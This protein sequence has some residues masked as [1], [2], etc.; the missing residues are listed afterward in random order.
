MEIVK[1]LNVPA[2]FFFQKMMDSVRYDIEQATGKQ[3]LVEQME[4]FTYVKEFSNKS[5]AKIQ[6]G[7]IEQDRSYGYQTS[8]NRNDFFATYEIRAIAHEKCE[9]RY[10]EKMHS[11]GLIQQLNDFTVSLLLGRFKKKR[12][13]AMLQAIEKAYE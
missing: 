11:H 3:L 13:K 6:I 5:S 2:A 8:T 7:S 4:N 12:F 1:E 9:I 10:H